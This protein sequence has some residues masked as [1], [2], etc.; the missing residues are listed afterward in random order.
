[1]SEDSCAIHPFGHEDT[2]S[3]RLH[4]LLHW[5]RSTG[6]KP[7]GAIPLSSMCAR[8]QMVTCAAFPDEPPWIGY[9]PNGTL[10]PEVATIDPAR[11]D[12]KVHQQSP[13]P[14]NPSSLK[15]STETMESKDAFQIPTCTDPTVS[16]CNCCSSL[17]TDS[18][19]YCC[20]CL[21]LISEH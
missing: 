8:G 9:S 15:A 2:G 16:L 20:G 13:Q 14:Y 11:A 3:S 12:L 5:Q 10:I 21:Q 4:D 6:T 7:D 19:G 1:M 18:Q 17:T